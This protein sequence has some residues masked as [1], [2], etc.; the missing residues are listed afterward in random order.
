MHC[1]LLLIA[2]LLFSL[3][4]HGYE[5]RN[6]LQKEAPLPVLKES[7]ITNQSWVKYPPYSDRQ[8]WDH[9]L[10]DSKAQLVKQGEKFLDYQWQVV[11]ASAYMEFERSGNRDVM[12]DPSNSNATAIRSLFLA[13]MAEGKGRFIPKLIDGLYYKC[14]MTSWALSAHLTVQHSKRTLPDHKEQVIDLGSGN[15][16]AMIAWIHYFLHDEFDKVNPVISERIAYEI[17]WKILTPYLK[18][19][20]FWW[21]ALN[22]KPGSHSF[23][24]NWN[25]WCNS[26]VI[27]CFL[28][29]EKNPERMLKAIHKS[30]LSVDQF[31]NYVKSDGACEEGPAYWGHAA[32]KLYDYLALL[33]KATNGKVSIFDKPIVKNM[34]EYISRSYVADNW[35]VNF[36]DASA[37]E[38]LDYPMIYRYGK[39][40]KSTELMQLASYLK[41][42]DN[43]KSKASNDLFRTFETLATTTEIDSE[44]PVHQNPPYSWYPETEFCYVVN[45]RCFFAA[46]G[47]HNNESHNH[48][49][50]GTFS[51]Y[52]NNYPVF[53]DA[54]VGTY[55]RQTFSGE[56]YSIW[57]MQSD[58]HNVPKIN[59]HSQKHGGSYKAKQTRFDPS[60]NCFSLDIAQAY[61]K[62]AGIRQW[63]RSYTV[64]K[65]QLA[66]EDSFKLENP[67]TANQIKFLTW[68]DIDQSQEGVL[69]VTVNGNKAELVYDNKQFEPT[70]TTIDIDDP[71]L[72]RVWGKQLRQITLTAKSTAS[73]GNYRF[74]IK[75]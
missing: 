48:N 40:T 70:V 2:C 39:D 46:K 8:A 17:D 11:P 23:V 72:A 35:V 56:R 51:L 18:E 20:R 27:Q 4:A 12:Q 60:K 65:D 69:A 55:T 67:T 58:Y 59:G 7:L 61:P 15:I 68:G 74:A 33:N 36:A 14:E 45:D 31:I 38:N 19:N 26:S 6:L 42:Q 1:Y 41:Q 13:E 47:G 54:G 32:G 49:D 22:S 52:L 25:P 5:E 75:Y 10:G 29:M 16:A 9:L 24:N 71:R 63:I 34:G 28:L 64:G 57:T 44:K 30:T 37:K 66:I 43:R 50:V 53:I 21:M 3:S 62:E 73:A